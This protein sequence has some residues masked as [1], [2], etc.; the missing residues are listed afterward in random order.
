M[1]VA[2]IPFPE[3]FAP[4]ALFN[5]DSVSW[6]ILSHPV[7]PPGMLRAPQPVQRRCLFAE[8]A[9]KVALNV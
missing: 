6:E 4:L 9:V 5:A 3:C 2:L 7:S 8:N 1:F